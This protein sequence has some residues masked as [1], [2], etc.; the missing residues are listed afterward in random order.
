MDGL[1]VSGLTK[2]FGNGNSKTQAIDDFN[3]EVGKGELLVLLGPSGCGKST[4]IRALAG[5]EAPDAGSITF[6]SQAVYD[7]ARG[8]DVRPHKRDIGMV[9]QSFAL[10]PHMTVRRNI[11]YPLQARRRGG[12]RQKLVEQAAEL[13]DC[14]KLLGRYPSQLSGGQQQRVALARAFVASPAIMLFDEPL[15]NLDAKLREQL[16]TDLHRLHRNVGF[17]GVYVTHDHAEALA[18]GDRLA[19]MRAGRI[20]HLGTPASVFSAPRT[21]YVAGFIGIE[22][23]IELHRTADR[24]TCTG[25][26]VHG[27]PAFQGDVVRLRIRKEDVRLRGSAMDL[28]SR[29]IGVAGATVVDVSFQGRTWEVVAEVGGV[30]VDAIVDGSDRVPVVGDTVVIAF[31]TQHALVYSATGDLVACAESATNHEIRSRAGV[32]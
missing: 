4:T 5:L 31:Q 18:L 6:G 30:R 32:C 11:A 7:A 27:D 8:I 19:I 15:S 17:T 13:I 20:E 22:N 29:E 12:N 21:E 28:T 9:F 14:T 25:G 2:S 16:R 24:W 10:W 23:V 1:T 3:V 26:E